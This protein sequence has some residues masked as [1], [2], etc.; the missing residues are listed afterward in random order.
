MMNGTQQTIFLRCLRQSKY[1]MT[2]DEEFNHPVIN[3]T[4]IKL[5]D[6]RV[7]LIDDIIPKGQVIENYNLRSTNPKKSTHNYYVGPNGRTKTRMSSDG[8]IKPRKPTGPRPRRSGFTPEQKRLRNNINSLRWQIENGR[9]RNMT[10]TLARLHRLEQE[11][12]KSLHDTRS[13]QEN[14]G[15]G[16]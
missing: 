16:L 9:R 4:A 7:I 3:P 11:L 10:T 6:G 1:W 2:K 15:S 14:T 5:R 8:T 13:S 12:E